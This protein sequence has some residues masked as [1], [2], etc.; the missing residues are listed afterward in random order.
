MAVDVL[1]GS[2]WFRVLCAYCPHSG[3][4]MNDFRRTLDDIEA[5]AMEAIDQGMKLILIGDFN[6]SIDEISTRE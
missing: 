3:Y 1:L 4:G 6:I 2:Q 5:L